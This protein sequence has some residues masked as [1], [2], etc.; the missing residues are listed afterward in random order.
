M[1]DTGLVEELLDTDHVDVVLAVDGD[2]DLSLRVGP[3]M[4]EAV[5]EAA[6]FGGPVG[7]GVAE[8]NDL[9]GFYGRL[10]ESPADR[11]L[12]VADPG[13]RPPAL[14]RVALPHVGA[15]R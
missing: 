2:L 12:R 13:A 3:R 11:S 9:R 5:W 8:M 15:G 6:D 14:R 1:P 7:Q 4:Y 10:A